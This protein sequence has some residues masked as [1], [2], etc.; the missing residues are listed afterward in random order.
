VRGGRDSQENQKD[1]GN[2]RRRQGTVS[3]P[4]QQTSEHTSQPI[5]KDKDRRPAGRPRWT[6]GRAGASQPTLEAMVGLKERE[7]EGQER[8]EEGMELS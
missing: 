2:K 1:Q 7:E 6:G 4:S 3:L 8:G 5:D